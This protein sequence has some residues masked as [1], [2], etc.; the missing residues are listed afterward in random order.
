MGFV[1]F[2]LCHSL[3]QQ[4]NRNLLQSFEFR[5]SL[6]DWIVPE[7]RDPSL[8]GYLDYN[9]IMVLIIVTLSRRLNCNALYTVQ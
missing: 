3:V 6:L 9:N 7:V 8:L 1:T 4:S 2:R 5:V